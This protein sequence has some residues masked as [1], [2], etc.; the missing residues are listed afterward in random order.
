M[1]EE[2]LK[3]TDYRKLDADY[4]FSRLVI[5]VRVKAG[6][7]LK[8]RIR[9]CWYMVDWGD[10]MLEKDLEHEYPESGIQHINI[11]GSRINWLNV[12]GWNA[13][14]IYIDRCPF[15]ARLRC[16]GN[17]LSKLN[18]INCPSLV[19]LDCSHNQLEY[20]QVAHLKKLKEVKAND[21]CLN[22][23]DFSGCSQLQEV[24]LNNNGL[25]VAIT[26]G[27]KKLERLWL[28]DAEFNPKEY[29]EASED[30]PALIIN[31]GGIL[32]VE[33][34]EDSLS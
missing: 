20:I 32:T 34:I 11:V 17:R 15:L 12:E 29:R 1:F 5:D 23:V 19:Y 9:S 24:D 16:Q 4:T 27:C 18:L 25:F 2:K 33:R 14:H 22:V 21:N 3:G 7:T 10:G 6:Q 31:E 26:R 28:D 13:T 8:L 30:L